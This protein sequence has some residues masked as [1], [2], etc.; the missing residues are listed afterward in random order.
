MYDRY[1]TTLQGARE[2]SQVRGGDEVDTEPAKI[3]SQIMACLPFPQLG[4]GSRKC[5]MICISAGYFRPDVIMLS[6]K[7][8]CWAFFKCLG[9]LIER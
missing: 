8:D 4:L 3:G 1:V 5:H 9:R 7:V 2:R 6:G